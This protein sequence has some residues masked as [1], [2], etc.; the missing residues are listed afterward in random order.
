MALGCFLFYGIPNKLSPIFRV[1]RLKLFV[2]IYSVLIAK[3]LVAT[4]LTQIGARF[5]LQ[6]ALQHLFCGV[7]QQFLVS[8]LIRGVEP[9]GCSVGDSTMVDVEPG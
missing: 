3:S 8:F 5:F 7:L 4:K 2:Y 6:G 9:E 1:E